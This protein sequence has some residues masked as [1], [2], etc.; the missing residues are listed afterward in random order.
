M[1]STTDPAL[2]R[3]GEVCLATD[4]APPDGLE[5]TATASS[6]RATAE[7]RK[8]MA[9]ERASAT[10]WETLHRVLRRSAGVVGGCRRAVQELR[11][12]YA[13][14][15]RGGAGAREGATPGAIRYQLRKYRCEEVEPRVYRETE[16]ELR[17]E[18]DKAQLLHD[19]LHLIEFKLVALVA[20]V[21]HDFVDLLHPILRRAHQ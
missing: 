9:E 3:L 15:P 10:D 13:I 11:D 5:L 1:W 8:R 12:R 19:F 21:H 2:D 7:G 17:Q 20:P 6:L 16:E 4:A 14:P 18:R